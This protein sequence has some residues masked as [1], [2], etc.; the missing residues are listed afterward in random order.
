MSTTHTPEPTAAD[1][2]GYLL[3][4]SEPERRAV[5]ATLPPETLTAIYTEARAELDATEGP[6][7]DGDAR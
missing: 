3:D 2:I 6:D 4:L 1:A 7:T 5:V